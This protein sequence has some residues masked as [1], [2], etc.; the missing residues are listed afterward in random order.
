M[1]Y[2]YEWSP[3]PH[4]VDVVCPSCTGHATFEA[5]TWVRIKLKKDVE[6]F[7][8]SRSFECHSDF[9]FFFPGL[10]GTGINAIKKLPKGYSRNDWAPSTYGSQYDGSRWGTVVCGSCG[11]RRKYCLNWPKDAYFQFGIRGKILW[12]YNRETAVA[13]RTFI[14]SPNRNQADFNQVL[15]LDVVPKHFLT[16]KVRKEVTQQ[17]DALLSDS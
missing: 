4:V 15:F 12:A 14:A 7:Q 2:R 11:I 9:A 5:A 17:V 3:M 6:F 13:L 16:A 1:T 8:R 10:D